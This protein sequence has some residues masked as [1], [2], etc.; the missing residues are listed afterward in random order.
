M[1]IL[2]F[3]FMIGFWGL[4]QSADAISLPVRQQVLAQARALL[5][6][7]S[8]SYVLG[9]NRLG[10]LAA[11]ESC[12]QCLGRKHPEASQRLKLCPNCGSCSLDCSHFTYEVFKLAGMPSSYLTTSLMKDLDADR[13][14]RSYHLIDVGQTSRR[15]LPGDLLVFDGH[16]VML[17][18][19]HADGT[20]D[21]I[22]VTS[23]RDL[24]GPGLGI[25]RERHVVMDSF[26]GPLLRV[27]RH[28]DL[29][30]ELRDFSME[31]LP[32]RTPKAD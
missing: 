1:N 28:V 2:F 17:E 12:N 10:D 27:L 32:S 16:V 30:R 19:K 13:L 6:N 31:R 21:L 22:H 4:P 18:K 8:I 7:W 25:Q 29:V 23:G 3:C 14:M 5:D 26:R 15:A 9:G 20:G 11:C 24:R